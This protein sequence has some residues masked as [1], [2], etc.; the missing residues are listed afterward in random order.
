MTYTIIVII[1][2]LSAVLAG[3]FLGNGAVY[4]FNRMPSKWLC[5]YD[6]KP[7]E[8][9]LD[10]S[11]QRVKSYP[12]KV[13]FT[14]FFVI[15]GIKMV[16]DD[17]RYAVASLLAIWA[18]LEVAIADKK[19]MIVPD[20]FI[21]LLAVT[22]L[23]FIPFHYSWK[24]CLIGGA[25][26]FGIMLTVGVMGKLIYKK[27]A[28]GGGDIKLFASLGLVSGGSGILAIFIMTTIFSAGHFILLL[29]MK[30]AKKG[31]VRPMVPYIMLSA[32]IYLVFL[33]G[34]GDI[35]YF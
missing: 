8:D 21:I 14:M 6:Q 29:I 35:L 5:D 18:L 32:T 2:C 23:G 10:N 33:W 9:M 28:L 12:W 22:A 20:Q 13:L 30:K 25:I 7:S 34:Y 4:F 17:P 3:I 24:T 11:S 1:K 31:D 15:I 26:G 16:M 19:Y 27:E